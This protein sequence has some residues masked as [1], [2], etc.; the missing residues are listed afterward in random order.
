MYCP[1]L[2]PKVSVFACNLHQDVLTNAC[3]CL[4]IRTDLD[5]GG[6][7]RCREH[8][9]L[10]INELVADVLWDEYGII[11]DLVVS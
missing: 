8:T 7:Y 4:A 9:D 11:S 5:G 6:I 3:R 10:L 2:V 1:E